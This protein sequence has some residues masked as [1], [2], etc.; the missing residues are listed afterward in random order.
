MIFVRAGARCFRGSCKWRIWGRA[1]NLR[2]TSFR[3]RPYQHLPKISKGVV[4]CIALSPV[5][6]DKVT[7]DMIK[8]YINYHKDH[9]RTPQQ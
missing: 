9:E 3:S 6:G 7:K 5:V 1:K 8:G 4:N 2:G